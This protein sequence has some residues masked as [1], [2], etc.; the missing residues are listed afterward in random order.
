MIC[1]K[2][3]LFERNCVTHA[4]IVFNFVSLDGK[5]KIGEFFSALIQI[6]SAISMQL[7]RIDSTDSWLEA[8]N[9]KNVTETGN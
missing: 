3:V 1:Y 7:R 8:Y 9:F 6:S 2:Q 5:D 4:D